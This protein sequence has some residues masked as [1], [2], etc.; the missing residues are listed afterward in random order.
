MPEAL[1]IVIFRILQEALNNIGKHSKADRVNLS[2]TKE[3]RNLIL[4]VE[5]NG[6]GFDPASLKSGKQ[7]VAGLGL[8]GMKERA[9]L[10]GG[11]F[12]IESRPRAGT[13]ICATWQ[14]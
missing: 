11:S 5:D 10:S 9:V 7:A 3:A 1:K 6:T 12:S 4:L 13:T 8:A 2:L 14:C